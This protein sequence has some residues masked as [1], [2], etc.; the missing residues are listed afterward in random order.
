MN[1]RNF[2]FREYA[3]GYMDKQKIYKA[4]TLG[5]YIYSYWYNLRSSA[6]LFEFQFL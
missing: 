5:F 3:K 2:N 6:P 1:K 4:K